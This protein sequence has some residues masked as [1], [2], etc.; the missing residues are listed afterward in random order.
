VS[1]AYSQSK[2]IESAA[3]KA[4]A[5]RYYRVPVDGT[6]FATLV[7]NRHI[8]TITP[9]GKNAFGD[10]HD[11]NMAVY[12]ADTNR[13][14][15]SSTSKID[16]VEKIG[17]SGSGMA[18]LKIM[19]LASDG[20]QESYALAFSTPDYQE[21]APGQ[22]DI[23][24]S[25]TSEVSATMKV[26]VNCRARNTGDLPVFAV[27][28]SLTAPAGFIATG[29]STFDRID[30]GKVQ[31]FTLLVSTPATARGANLYTVGLSG[32]AYGDRISAKSAMSVNVRAAKP[33]DCT[34][35]IN[36]VS[37]SLVLTPVAQSFVISVSFPGFD[38][39]EPGF[40]NWSQFAASSWYGTLPP[41]SGTGDTKIV[42]NVLSAPIHPLKDRSGSVR[43]TVNSASSYYN[44]KQ[45][46][47]K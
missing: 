16:N 12:D 34:P 47:G 43:I 7:W 25:G 19:D 33:Q 41:G 36:P 11:L 26:T 31:D 13:G 2:S 30:A 35:V 42:V 9:D 28:V 29:P 32:I 3:I 10:F 38:P 4:G 14:V 46:Y 24:C 1:T 6:M 20:A 5:A 21:L 22:L 45:L 44:F 37:G 15:A 18:V 8:A 40:C 27:G 39:Q 23:Q 17:V